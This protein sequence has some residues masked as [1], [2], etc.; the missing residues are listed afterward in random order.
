MRDPRDER[1]WRWTFRTMLVLV[2]AVIALAVC[3][4][5]LKVFGVVS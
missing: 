2:F 4:V 1:R 3:A 5:L